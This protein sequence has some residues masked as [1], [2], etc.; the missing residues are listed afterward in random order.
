MNSMHHG[1][2]LRSC[3]KS[4][5]KQGHIRQR[6]S[7]VLRTGVPTHLNLRGIARIDPACTWCALCTVYISKSIPFLG[8]V[9][10]LMLAAPSVMPT[11]ARCIS[12][13]TLPMPQNTSKGCLQ[14]NRS[15]FWW[16]S[17]KTL[18]QSA[19]I[20]ACHPRRVCPVISTRLDMALLL[21]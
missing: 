13:I 2:Y 5:P 17:C 18:Q 7:F 19:L 12:K 8:I 20:C 21:G 10:I 14:G 1:T 4:S 6:T 15:K 3:H 9:V 16:F 11:Q